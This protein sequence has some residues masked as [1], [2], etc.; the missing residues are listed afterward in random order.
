[1]VEKKTLKKILELNKKYTAGEIAM[2]TGLGKKLVIKVLN[3][4]YEKPNVVIG[5]PS[6]T[7]SLT[8]DQIIRAKTLIQFGDI[9]PAE[10]AIDL[11]V[12][13]REILMVTGNLK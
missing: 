5:R 4:S 8:T 11:G 2:I 7:L 9:T 3:D 12:N 13:V 10:I 6:K 1:M